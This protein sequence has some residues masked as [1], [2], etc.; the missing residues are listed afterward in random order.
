MPK[1]YQVPFAHTFLQFDVPTGWLVD[2]AE[3]TVTAQSLPSEKIEERLIA[4]AQQLIAEHDPSRKL[5]FVF[6]DATRASP[7]QILLEPIARYL[8]P[9]DLEIEFICAIGM[10]R[11]STEA[12]KRAKL[13]DWIVDN[14]SVTDHNP[15][16]VVQVG[17]IEGV[18]IELNPRLLNATVVGVGVV[19]P[20]QY[21]G[22]SG[23]VKTAVIGCGGV[24]TIG[25]TH[26]IRFLDDEGTRLGK[27]ED[28]PFQSFLRQA[29]AQ[30]GQSWAVNVIL[31]A[32][33]E[34]L[35][36]AAGHPNDV[37]DEL[38][39]KARQLYEIV[40]PNAPYDVAVA[41]IGAPKDANL[42]QATR[43]ATY[44]GLSAEPMIRRGGVIIVPASLP[45]GGGQGQGEHNFMQM[46]H[47]FGP[48]REMMGYLRETGFRPGDQRAFM[49]AKL[50]QYY[51]LIIVG[52]PKQPIFEANL[53]H[54]ETMDEAL[55]AAQKMVRTDTPK[56]LI[57][58]HALQ[59]LPVELDSQ[60]VENLMS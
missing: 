3:S 59:T 53:D 13:G 21:A 5:I 35:D 57:V 7:D 30:I 1:K 11:P 20:H 4:F 37:H 32:D 49:V 56:L 23:G 42:Y 58:P 50:R 10:H 43:G 40:V 47:R 60:A 6:T 15:H 14:F 33:Y 29:G 19:E 48:T 27:I 34:I 45:E 44:L 25:I 16:E 22:Y 55:Y 39:A 12:E 31:S 38:V 18:P 54:A 24:N 52:S 17:D 26:G 46:M 8:Q 9:Y 41:G 2:V 28:N 36:L 51:R